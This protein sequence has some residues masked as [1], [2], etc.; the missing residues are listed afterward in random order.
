MKTRLYALPFLLLAP[1]AVWLG[2]R[3]LNAAP[4]PAATPA[5]AQ[6]FVQR[7]NQELHAAF[8]KRDRINWVNQTYITDDTTALASEGEEMV[9]ELIARLVK[10]S[11][12]F[13]GL[14]L[15]D[16][17]ARQLKLLKLSAGLPAPPDATERKEL[18]EIATWL[19]SVYGKGSYCKAG[20]CK[21]LTALSKILAESRN[22]PELREAWTGWH[23]ISV[24]MKDKY[25]RYVDLANKG[26]RDL[27]FKDFGEMWKSRYDMTPAEFEAETERLWTQV[28]PLYDQLHCYVR[29][30]LR[31]HYGNV[32][33]EKGPIPAHLLGNMWAQEWANIYPL[34][35]PY[36]GQV[37]LDVTKALQQKG[38]D[39]L[40]MVKLGESFF[41][42]LGL[43]PLPASFWERSMFK[44]PRDR[45]V[46]C[47][48]S[49]WDVSY[50]DDLRI[51]MCIKVDEEDL[52][53]IHHE[54][55]HNYYYHYYY[56]LPVL[57]QDGANDGF[58]EGIGDTLALSVTPEY[59]KTVG[60]L[61]SVPSNEKA[62]INLQMKDALEKIAFLPFGKLIDQWRWN[63]FNGKTAPKDYNKSWW[64]LRTKYQGVS[65]PVPRADTDFDPGAKYHVPA[66]VPYTRYF[67][68][69]ILQFQFH[70]ALCKLSGHKGALHTCSIYG[71]KEAGKRMKAMLSMGSSKPWPEALFALTGEKKMDATAMIDYFAPLR[72]WLEQQNKGKAC[73]W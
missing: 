2:A 14:K 67:L 7:A 10:E 48:A 61:D 65:A 5:E 68:A 29:G 37:S 66:N 28:K 18:A 70:R 6:A 60:L 13:D 71:N 40:K 36:S 42:S 41:T 33:P 31:A 56:K 11:Q 62:L 19:T 54:L 32:V 1:A 55:G 9:M 64:E 26:A 59:L 8:A 50:N 45:E 25:A 12:R 44:K 72:K 16:D 53:T 43:D 4:A 47:H 38:Y 46:V 57:Y 51:K 73:G 17:T 30:K 58:H 69:R 52:I 23:G 35:E 20:E 24:P 39:E 22:E 3:S 27:G 15:D 34:V 21:D 63:V 49:A